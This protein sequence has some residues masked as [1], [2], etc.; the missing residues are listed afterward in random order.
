MPLGR[1][2]RDMLKTKFCLVYEF[3]NRFGVHIL[4]AHYYAPVPNIVELKK[5]IDI[6]ANRLGMTGIYVDLDEQVDN[7]RMVCAPF[8]DEYRGNPHYNRAMRFMF[9][10]GRSRAFGYIEAQV[11]H[12]AVRYF[13]PARVIEIGSGIPTYCTYQATQKNLADT[14]T[15][16]SII[17]IEPDP[18]AI[19]SHLATS[20]DHVELLSHQIQAIPLELFQRLSTND[21]VSIDSNHV[22]KTGGEVNYVVLEILPRLPAGV[23]VQI[24]D[25]YLP[26]DYQRDAL[27]TFI[28]TNETSIL[29]A[30]LAYNTRFRILFALS[31]LHHD[32]RGEMRSIL[33]EYRPECDWYGMRHG[34][35]DPSRH[36]PSSLWLRVQA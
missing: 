22:V 36:F 35:Y 23:I 30:F 28:H 33:P 32:R 24:H 2:L 25:V 15:S 34:K 11:L 5:D 13:K 16:G 20:T 14:G 10:R 3:A 7:L 29:S 6:W 1:R 19:V 21:I 8:Q 26:Y 27:Q 17:C 31:M 9:G 4:P 18:I 12:S